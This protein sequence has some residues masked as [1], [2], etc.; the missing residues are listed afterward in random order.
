MKNTSAFLDNLIRC[1]QTSVGGS[2]WQRVVVCRLF[3]AYSSFRQFI[4]G[5]QRCIRMQK[6]QWKQAAHV[7][8]ELLNWESHSITVGQLLSVCHKREHR[9]MT[10]RLD[11]HTLCCCD[12]KIPKRTTKMRQYLFLILEGSSLLLWALCTWAEYPDKRSMW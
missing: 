10:D 6:R 5:T 12:H 11:L 8:T 3:R 2:S 4:H 1:L 7:W 9:T